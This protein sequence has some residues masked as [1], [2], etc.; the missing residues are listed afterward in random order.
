MA[1]TLLDVFPDA[2]RF[3]VRI[4]ATDIDPNVVAKARAGVYRDDAVAPI[5]AAMR[6]RWLCREGDRDDRSWRIKDEVRALIAFKQLNLIGN[7]PMQ[8][9]FDVIFCRNVVI[10]FEEATQAFLWD[11]FKT[12]MAP[13]ARLY[14]GHS[15]RIDVDGFVSDGLTIYRQASKGGR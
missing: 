5:P 8:G 1:L 7:W 2:A 13:E 6:E 9:K 15:E 3:D 11:R 10:Y 4:L 12:V 14:I